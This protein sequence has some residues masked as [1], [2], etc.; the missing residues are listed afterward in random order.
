MASGFFA[1]VKVPSLS[2]MMLARSRLA[3]QKR[4]SPVVASVKCLWPLQ[5]RAH[6]I[7]AAREVKD[8]VPSGVL[9]DGALQRFRVVGHTIGLC[10]VRRLGHIHHVLRDG[11]GVGKKRRCG[12]REEASKDRGFS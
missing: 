10:G 5:R 3:A 6:E 2:R 7:G 11:V 8:A 12:E 4:L 1:S 9:V